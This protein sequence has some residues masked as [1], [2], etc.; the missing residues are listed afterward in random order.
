MALRLASSTFHSARFPPR[1]V[2]GVA[3]ALAVCA[4]GAA[5]LLAVA[6]CGAEIARQRTRG[7]SHRPASAS[8]HRRRGHGA[9]EPNRHSAPNQRGRFPRTSTPTNRSSAPTSPLNVIF[10]TANL[11]EVRLQARGPRDRGRKPPPSRSSPWNGTL[12]ADLPTGRYTIAPP[13]SPA[14]R[15]PACRRPLPHL[16]RERR[17][18]ALVARRR[19]RPRAISAPTVRDSAPWRLI[20]HVTDRHVTVAAR[21]RRRRSWPRRSSTS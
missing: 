5:M 15:P 20:R 8:R 21:N 13:T 11:T 17:P 10:V 12:Q 1:W 6:G 2:V 4:S 19:R 9:A 3:S 18:A 16:L 7:P 14:P